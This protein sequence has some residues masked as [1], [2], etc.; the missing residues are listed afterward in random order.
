[1]YNFSAK[2]C[3]AIIWLKGNFNP[4]ILTDKKQRHQWVVDQLAYVKLHNL[5]GINVDFESEI[6]QPD[7][8]TRNGLTAIMKELKEA[9]PKSQ[10]DED[11]T[12]MIYY[13]EYNAGKRSGHY[14]YN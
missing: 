5:D 1:M 6:F 10:V 4:S 2:L 8:Q 12:I 11:I 14:F 7:I 3:D 9:L 13:N